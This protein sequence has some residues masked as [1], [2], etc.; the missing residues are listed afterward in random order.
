MIGSVVKQVLFFCPSHYPFRSFRHIFPV[1]YPCYSSSFSRWLQL[2]VSIGEHLFFHSSSCFFLYS[3]SMFNDVEHTFND[4]ELIFSDVEHT[5]SVVELK[6]QVG[7]NLSLTSG[8]GI[9]IYSQRNLQ[10]V[11]AA[12]TCSI[13]RQKM[14][15]GEKKDYI[16]RRIYK[17]K[18]QFSKENCSFVHP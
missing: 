9:F 10:W 2:Y 5:F 17:Q 13:I 8:K 12:T 15:I 3:K 14:Y 18:E 6:Y 16:I 11:R 7:L 1:V 4:V